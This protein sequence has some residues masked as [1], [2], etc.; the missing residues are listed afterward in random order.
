[1]S[2]NQ[3]TGPIKQLPRQQ[4]TRQVQQPAAAAPRVERLPVVLDTGENVCTSIYYLLIYN[5]LLSYK[6]HW[7]YH[8]CL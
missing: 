6:G 3:V 4:A 8:N 7:T 2:V 1:M 5:S